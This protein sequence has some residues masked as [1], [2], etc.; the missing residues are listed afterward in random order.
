ME[1]KEL[2]TYMVKAMV[3]NPEAVEV[4]EVE[5]ENT[6]IIEL[7]VRKDDLGKV[8]GKEGRN[9]QALRTIMSAASAKNHKR[10]VLEIVE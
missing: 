9:A 2:V 1:I 7:K 6:S 5:S 10:A 4:S 3:D 8:I